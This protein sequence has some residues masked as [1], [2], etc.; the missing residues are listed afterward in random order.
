MG[1]IMPKHHMHNLSLRRHPHKNS[2][3]GPVAG[4][5]SGKRSLPDS[6]APMLDARH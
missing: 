3:A 2:S 4:T 6:N 1:F 5:A